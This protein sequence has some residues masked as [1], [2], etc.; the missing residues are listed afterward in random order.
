MDIKKF[1]SEVSK[2]ASENCMEAYIIGSPPHYL[3]DEYIPDGRLLKLCP[4]GV[5]TR[6]LLELDFWG[7]SARIYR[8]RDYELTQKYRGRAVGFE[9][10]TGFI[11]ANKIVAE[12]IVHQRGQLTAVAESPAPTV[13]KRSLTVEEI[14]A[15]ELVCN[16][17][18]C[19]CN[20]MNENCGRCLGSGSYLVDG[21]GRIV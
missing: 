20:G 4:V 13:P 11:L 12:E 19:S 17:V 5:K 2:V 6:V 16:N 10:I 7:R 21:F 14:A 15:M 18:F 9:W 1:V 3:N 8:H